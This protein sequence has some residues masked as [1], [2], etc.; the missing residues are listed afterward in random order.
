[1]KVNRVPCSF[2]ANPCFIFI[3]FHKFTAGV[4]QCSLSS[5]KFYLFSK[6]VPDGH[7]LK[8]RRCIRVL[9][10][11][12]SA[13]FYSY[14]ATYRPLRVAVSPFFK[15]STDENANLCRFSS[16]TLKGSSWK[17]YFNT[18]CSN[19]DSQTLY[20]DWMTS[21]LL[22]GQLFGCCCDQAPATVYLG[23]PVLWRRS[24]PATGGLPYPSAQHTQAFQFSKWCYLLTYMVK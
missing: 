18:V 10:I 24:P 1:M 5:N 2:P 22:A 23:E 17:G 9:I 13:T 21:L 3:L 14:V 11:C 19:G 4:A 20:G 12:F 15:N 7:S 8:K 6:F 16:S